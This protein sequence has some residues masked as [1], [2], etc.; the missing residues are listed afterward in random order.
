M[1]AREHA[2]VQP[3]TSFR[4]PPQVVLGSS[5]GPTCLGLSCDRAGGQGGTG[6]YKDVAAAYNRAVFP[7]T[8]ACDDEV[9]Q[10]CG[11]G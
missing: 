4:P 6:F 8:D 10:R 3:W 7:G 5:R 2:P 11:W 1:I 9:T